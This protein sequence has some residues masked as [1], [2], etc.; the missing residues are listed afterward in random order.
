MATEQLVRS[1]ID[2]GLQ[3][4]KALDEG[5]FG[6]AAALWLYSS[7]PESWK[8]VIATDAKPEALE[9]KYLEAATIASK[10]RAQNPDRPILDLSSVR[11]VSVNDPLI[12]GL[13]P[14]LRVDGLSEVRFSHNMING[15]YVEDALIHRL[16]A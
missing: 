6:V 12:K 15:I 3:L 16:A 2:A 11:I 14:I 10:W 13:R 9:K 7:D 1:E 8:F 4:V 5:G